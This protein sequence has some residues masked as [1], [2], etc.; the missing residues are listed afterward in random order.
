[1][2]AAP[3]P[4]DEEGR[5]LIAVVGPCAAGKSTLV[6]GLQAKGYNARQVAQE[7]SYVP[8]MW[9]I[10]TQPDVLLYIDASF[11]HC[12][13]RKQLSWNERDYERQIERL[14]HARTHC[15]FYLNTDAINPQEAL[16]RVLEALEGLLSAK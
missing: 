9:Q 11:E 16:E 1:M 5:P 8:S 4:G 12:T 6:E 7:H 14:A 13:E 15:D 10:L 2:P 3:K